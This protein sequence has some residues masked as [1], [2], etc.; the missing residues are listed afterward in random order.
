MPAWQSTV[1]TTPAATVKR[2]APGTPATTPASNTAQPKASVAVV[3]TTP[4]STVKQGF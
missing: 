1:A 4:A 2:A 3:A